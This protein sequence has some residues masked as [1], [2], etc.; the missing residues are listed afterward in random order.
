MAAAKETAATTE[1]AAIGK[2]AAEAAMEGVAA[3]TRQETVGGCNEMIQH[4]RQIDTI[5]H[6]NR[7]GAPPSSHGK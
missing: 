2:A 5:R 7:G 1:E 4:I 6:V 3:M